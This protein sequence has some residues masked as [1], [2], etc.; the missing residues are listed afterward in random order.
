MEKPK[1]T[2]GPVVV[3]GGANIDIQGKSLAPFRPKDSNPG[4]VEKAAGGVGRNIAESCVRLGLKVRLV[5]VFGSDADGHWLEKDCKAKGIDTALSLHWEGS[6]PIYL[7]TLDS[8]GSLVAAIADMEAMESLVPG[9]LEGLRDD[10][11]EAACIVV[12]TNIPRESLEWLCARYGRT[13][14]LVR[15]EGREGR[16]R[17]QKYQIGLSGPLLF[18]DPVSEIKALKAEGLTGE[19]H[20]IKPNWA[21]ARALTGLFTPSEPPVAAFPNPEALWQRMADAGRL[22]GEMYVSLGPGGIYYYGEEEEGRLPLPPEDQRPKVRNRSGA[23]DAALA[24]LVWASLENFRPRRKAAYAIAA[25]LLAAASSSP[26]PESLNKG[27]LVS[28]AERIA[29]REHE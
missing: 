6:S 25:A 9:A 28:L 29:A 17:C 22:P 10:L 3:I 13:K 1:S 7:C 12:D 5:T 18:L 4:T 11:D 26:A 21:E 14:G 24:A 2:H 15:G 8:D 27:T 19:F 23:G 16:G 20:C